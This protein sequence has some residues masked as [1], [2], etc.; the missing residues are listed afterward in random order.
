[1]KRGSFSDNT[2]C[3]KGCFHRNSELTL[4][5]PFVDPLFKHRYP[6][7]GAKNPPS[8][9][10]S[11]PWN[12]ANRN[13]SPARHDLDVACVVKLQTNK[14]ILRASEAEQAGL[15]LLRKRNSDVRFT[16]DMAHR[17]G[18]KVTFL[19]AVNICIQL[20]AGSVNLKLTPKGVIKFMTILLI[21]LI[22]QE[23]YNLSCLFM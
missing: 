18:V 8:L 3:E 19:L 6:V 4:Q 9:G 15:G 22:A 5:G 1:M 10:L 23:I 7:G 17:Q 20:P 16:L 13:N 12:S 2:A 14:E 11:L 21:A